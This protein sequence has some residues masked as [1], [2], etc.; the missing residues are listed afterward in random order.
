MNHRELVGL[1]RGVASRF[2][3]K[4][5]GAG[6]VISNEDILRDALIQNMTA[7]TDFP[8][9]FIAW[10]E[11][12]QQRGVTFHISA[13]GVDHRALADAFVSAYM[14]PEDAE[15]FACNL[16]EEPAPEIQRAFTARAEG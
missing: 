6:I 13:A 14:Q 4:L 5:K 11:Q 12:G 7:E 10:A 9:L 3:D 15:R 8:A 16:R 2:I 1:A